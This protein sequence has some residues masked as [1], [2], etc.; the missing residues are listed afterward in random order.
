MN[1]LRR[2]PSCFILWITKNRTKITWSMVEEE[3]WLLKSLPNQKISFCHFFSN[4]TCFQEP[5]NQSYQ[6]WNFR[7]LTKLAI[8]IS[9]QR[10]TYFLLNLVFLQLWVA[11]LNYSHSNKIVWSDNKI[12]S[13]CLLAKRITIFQHQ[14]KCP[15]P[16]T[17]EELHARHLRPG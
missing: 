2:L 7:L 17:S 3:S 13:R 14:R 4:K 8:I 6:E 16:V 5:I 12:L 9:S 1:S 10:I 15:G 11:K